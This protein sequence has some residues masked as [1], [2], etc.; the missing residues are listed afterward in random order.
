MTTSALKPFYFYFLQCSGKVAGSGYASGRKQYL[1]EESEKELA[2]LIKLLS[3]RGFPPTKRDVQSIAFNYAKANNIKGFSD[4]KGTAGYYGIQTSASAAR[5]AGLNPS[6]VG[7]WFQ[8]YEDLLEELAIKDVPSH[9]WNCDE[10]G[11]Q[12]QFC[13]IRVVGEVGKRCV[14][15]TAGKKGETMTVLAAFNAVGTFSRNLVA[16][17][18]KEDGKTEAP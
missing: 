1:S 9:T 4:V 5:A 6:M 17:V 16:E 13:S 3:K 7:K 8:Q 18:D 15:V 14:E 12:D 2:D 10:S 11:L